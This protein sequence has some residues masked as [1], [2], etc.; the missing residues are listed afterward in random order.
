MR[1]IAERNPIV[2]LVTGDDE[3]HLECTNEL[4]KETNGIAYHLEK[5]PLHGIPVIDGNISNSSTLFEEQRQI[6]P[7]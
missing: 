4:R 1:E 5:E 7:S 6:M 2:V 3:F